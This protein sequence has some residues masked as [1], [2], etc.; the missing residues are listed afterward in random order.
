MNIYLDIDGVLITKDGQPAKSVIP[1]L[2][3]V[4]DNHQAYWLTT[5][6]KGDASNAVHYLKG[7][8]GEEVMPYL[9]KIVATDWQTLKTEG[10]DFNQDFRWLDDYVL[11]A[12]LNILEKHDAK[13][14]II[15]INL[16]SEPDKLI[17]LVNN[18]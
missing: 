9:T 1:F 4:T 5:H 8:L 15:L 2:K 17:Q 13:K 16:K 11:Q 7:I 12:E 6:C 18:I 3:Y 10:I 14:K